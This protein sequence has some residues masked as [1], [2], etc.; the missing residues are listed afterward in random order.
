MIEKLTRFIKT[1]FCLA[2]ILIV[3][4]STVIQAQDASSLEIAPLGNTVELS[5]DTPTEDSYILETQAVLMEGEEW[6]PLMQF[7]G[8]ATQPRNWVDPICGDKDAKYFRL[9]QLLEAPE[10]RSVTFD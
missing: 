9:R 4:P 6:E 3:H 1:V 10:Q 7:R 8:N 2:A 5:L